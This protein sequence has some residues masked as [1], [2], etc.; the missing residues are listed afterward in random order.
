MSIEFTKGSHEWLLENGRRAIFTL[1]D[2][3]AEDGTVIPHD[4]IGYV[5]DASSS[6]GHVDTIRIEV[7]RGSKQPA[8]A[9]RVQVQDLGSIWDWNQSDGTTQVV[10][11]ELLNAC[12]DLCIDAFVA[13]DEERR[14]DLLLSLYRNLQ[15]AI[16]TYQQLDNPIVTYARGRW[17]KALS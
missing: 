3:D 17:L 9:V 4:S 1:V 15:S 13:P 8:Q 16:G 7:S 6:N 10:A 11:S 12:R 2:L 5:C 14:K